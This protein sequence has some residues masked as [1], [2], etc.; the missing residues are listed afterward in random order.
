[1]NR[2]V[3]SIA[4]PLTFASL[5]ASSDSSSLTSSQTG[6]PAT[7]HAGYAS[8]QNKRDHMEDRHQI[9]QG[10][11][12][13]FF[14]VY[15]GHNG[16]TVAEYAQK[17][18]HHRI[19]TNRAFQKDTK[20]AIFEAFYHLHL[21]LDN[22]GED[23]LGNPIAWRQG[24]TAA[25]ALIKDGRLSL[26]WAGDSRCV[27]ARSGLEP[28]ETADHK[29]LVRAE[30]DRIIKARG[31]VQDGIWVCDQERTY[32]IAMTRALGDKVLNNYGIIPLPQIIECELHKNNEFLILASDGIWDVISSEEAIEIVKDQLIGQSVDNSRCSAAAGALMQEAIKRGSRDNLTAV[33]VA[34]KDSYDD[35]VNVLKVKDEPQPAYINWTSLGTLAWNA[36]TMPIALAFKAMRSLG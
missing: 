27:L 29:I 9:Y 17:Y 25:T 36:I 16:A 4:I 21:E 19:F 13:S 2:I 31:L 6:N 34:L 3:A 22:L 11:E 1:M 10:P 14:A 7:Y 24:S 28:I 32:G 33:V 8:A 23:A 15:D 35:W 30:L 5:I 20:N 12:G 18:L 26:A